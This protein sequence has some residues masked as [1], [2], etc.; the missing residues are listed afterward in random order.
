MLTT[1]KVQKKK[2]GKSFPKSQ[3]YRQQSLQNAKQQEERL[4][5]LLL[6]LEETDQR[7]ASP[8]CWGTDAQAQITHMPLPTSGDAYQHFLTSSEYLLLAQLAPFPES[9]DR[10]ITKRRGPQWNAIPPHLYQD[11]STGGFNVR[12]NAMPKSNNQCVHF[13]LADLAHI[14][15]AFDENTNREIDILSEDLYSEPERLI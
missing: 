3:R 1:F 15:E 7:F 9:D 11:Y 6:E 10:G 2:I 14:N 12:S 13:C 8:Q 4:C 5:P